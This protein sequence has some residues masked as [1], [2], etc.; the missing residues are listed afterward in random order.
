MGQAT[1]NVC[2]VQTIATCQLKNWSVCNEARLQQSGNRP[3]IRQFPTVNRAWP[4]VFY[5]IQQ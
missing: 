2:I 5:V 1:L 3:R 4:I